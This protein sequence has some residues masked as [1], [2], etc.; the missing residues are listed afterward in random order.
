MVGIGRVGAAA[1][2][3]LSG[4]NAVYMDKASDLPIVDLGYQIQRAANFNVCF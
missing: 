2:M 3:L 4:A 1:A